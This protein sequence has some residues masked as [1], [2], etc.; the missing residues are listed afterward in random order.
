M[1]GVKA[2]SKR[3]NGSSI[4]FDELEG[5]YCAELIGSAYQMLGLLS[6][7]LDT[8]LLIPGIPYIAETDSFQ[9]SRDSKLTEFIKRGTSLDDEYL[10]DLHLR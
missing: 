1:L 3:K 2:I 10:I 5:V 9:Q 4:D 6:T 8:T 7:D